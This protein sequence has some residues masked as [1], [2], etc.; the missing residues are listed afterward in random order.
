MPSLEPIAGPPAPTPATLV[1]STTT[2]KRHSRHVVFNSGRPTKYG[3]PSASGGIGNAGKIR[4][5]TRRSKASI[6]DPD[7]LAHG[8][9]IPRLVFFF[10][11]N[12]N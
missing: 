2:S 12:L 4:N 3:R 10:K 1:T 8:T 6:E 11:N 5:S 7:Y 9:G